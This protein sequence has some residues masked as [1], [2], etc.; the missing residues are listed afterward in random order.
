[1]LPLRSVILR[2]RSIIRRDT[3]SDSW[4]LCSNHS[5]IHVFG[6]GRSAA[7]ARHCALL[8]ALAK[9][10]QGR[11]F[12]FAAQSCH[13]LRIVVTVS[14]FEVLGSYYSFG[15]PAKLTVT[16]GSSNLMLRCA[17]TWVQGQSA[18]EV[19]SFLLWFCLLR[20]H[21]L[22]GNLSSNHT[23]ILDSWNAGFCI[24]YMYPAHKSFR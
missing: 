5:N 13:G 11:Q 4:L 8:L 1:M 19:H 23:R 12:G 15:H 20:L 3:V 6:A 24:F 21:D 22:V 17:E 18:T 2:R 14:K 9:A 16:E 7:P 10:R